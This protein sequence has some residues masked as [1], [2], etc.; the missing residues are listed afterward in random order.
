MAPSTRSIKTPTPVYAFVGIGDLAVEKLRDVRLPK[1]DVKTV[2]DQMQT[3]PAKAQ[4]AVTSAFH[5]ALTQ[6]NTVY[7]HLATRGETLVTR[8]RGQEASAELRKQA[9]RT[10]TQAKATKTTAKKATKSTRSRA[11]ATTT[12]AKKTAEAGGEATKSAADKVGD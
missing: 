1:T 5:D 7:G 3:A 11:K 9:G 2:Q 4:A 6:A 12:S 10:A 8:I